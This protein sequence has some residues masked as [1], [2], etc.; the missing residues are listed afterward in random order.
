MVWLWFATFC[1]WSFP[2]VWFLVQGNPAVGS[3]NRI[4]L[5]YG[6]ELF[7]WC[8]WMCPPGKVTFTTGNK[9][10]P[11]GKALPGMLSHA[12]GWCW[13]QGSQPWYSMTFSDGF[14]ILHLSGPHT[15]S[16]YWAMALSHI[17]FLFLLYSLFRDPLCSTRVD[18]EGDCSKARQARSAPIRGWEMF[19]MLKKAF[20]MSLCVRHEAKDGTASGLRHHSVVLFIAKVHFLIFWKTKQVLSRQECLLWCFYVLLIVSVSNARPLCVDV[21]TDIEVSV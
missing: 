6:S 7:R 21:N 14:P 4:K 18:L 16:S 15:N 1:F 17:V 2:L 19:L 8:I 9:P 13:E 10:W 20:A 12:L 5:I 11:C 3:Q